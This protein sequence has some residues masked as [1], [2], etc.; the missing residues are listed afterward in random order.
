MGLVKK[1]FGG[2][3]ILSQQT[4]GAPFLGLYVNKKTYSKGPLIFSL[5]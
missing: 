1:L 4:V 2:V 3:Y 5:V